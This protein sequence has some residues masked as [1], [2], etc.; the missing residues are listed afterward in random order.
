MKFLSSPIGKFPASHHKQPTDFSP[1]WNLSPLTKTGQFASRAESGNSEI[2][3]ASNNYLARNFP[4]LLKQEH[5][6]PL[7]RVE[8]SDRPTFTNRRLHDEDELFMQNE[9][10]LGLVWNNDGTK[11]FLTNKVIPF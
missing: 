6:S 1:L 11:S 8:D 9:D 3:N 2:P 4:F 10:S 5:Y 7:R